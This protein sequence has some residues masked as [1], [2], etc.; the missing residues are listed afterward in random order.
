MSFIKEVADGLGLD[1][2]SGYTAINF[3]GGSAYV[4]GITKILY[5]DSV[6]V[7]FVCGRKKLSVT[8]KDLKIK[9]IGGG[10]A[11]IVGKVL[12]LSE[13]EPS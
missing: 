6:L 5:V 12:S 4:E 10:A 3:G 11:T 1:A 13:E 8:G 2:L 9:E 7:R